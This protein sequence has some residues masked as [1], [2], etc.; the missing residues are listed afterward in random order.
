MTT[1]A[2]TPITVPTFPAP[3]AAA[4]PATAAPS[5]SRTFLLGPGLSVAF[6]VMWTGGYIA[7]P[8][9]VTQASPL[10]LCFWRFGVAAVILA[11]LA[12]LTHARWP[13]GRDAW[14][15]V[16]ATG[17]L[18]QAGMFSFCYL[19]LA[20]GV[21]VAIVAIA[22]GASPVLV[23]LGGTFTLGERLSPLQW[24]GTL[25]GFAGLAVAIAGEWQAVAIGA[26]AL[27]PVAGS[28]AFA[29]GT[30]V[31]RRTGARMDLRTGTAVQMTV[32]AAVTLPLALVFE[33]G[34]AIPVNGTSVGVVM[35]LAIG[36]SCIA[37]ALTFLMLRHRQA[38]DTA[39]LMLLVTPLATFAA[40]P[41]FGQRP[42]SLLWT[43]LAITV[44]GIVLATRPRKAEPEGAVH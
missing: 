21:P 27:L 9:G 15:Q 32:A 37:S 39:R 25:L 28:I 30:L 34:I 26:A 44:T 40:W 1:E 10:A 17:L 4:T 24:G 7:G 13:Q 5:R 12:V 35:F 43:G 2:P 14:I 38:A 18:M 22:I 11:I 29:A 42:D 6:V 3:P 36:N 19:G 23:A 41:L 33:G 31:Q 16:V 20:L 8:I